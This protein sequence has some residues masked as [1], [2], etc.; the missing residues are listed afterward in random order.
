VTA[1]IPVIQDEPDDAEP[2]RP[3][4]AAP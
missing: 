3:F 4:R 2:V 1:S